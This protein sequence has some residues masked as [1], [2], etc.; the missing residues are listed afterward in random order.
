MY[1]TKQTSIKNRLEM[2]MNS[3]KQKQIIIIKTKCNDPI[4]QKFERK[5]IE[6]RTTI[7]T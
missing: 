3:K 6:I 5:K 7:A 4:K 1:Q 2:L